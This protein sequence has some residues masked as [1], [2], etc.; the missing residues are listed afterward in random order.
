MGKYLSD[1]SSRDWHLVGSDL[2]YAFIR[3][4]GTII[5]KR[6]AG[7][8]KILDKRMRSIDEYPL[9]ARKL[10][11]VILNIEP[12][13]QK[14]NRS[15]KKQTENCYPLRYKIQQY[16]FVYGRKESNKSVIIFQES[17]CFVTHYIPAYYKTYCFAFQKRLF[18]T[19]KA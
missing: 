10:N 3:S 4:D 5:E 7:N 19:V 16:F 13:F 8:I 15:K 14:R 6:G 18:C 1:S 17:I 2:Y 9:D 11:E 12:F